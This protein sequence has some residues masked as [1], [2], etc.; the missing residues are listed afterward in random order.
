MVVLVVLG[1]ISV[2]IADVLSLAPT[3]RWFVAGDE[4]TGDQRDAAMKLPGRQSA[5][6]FAAWG[7]IVLDASDPELHRIA[8][9]IY[10][11]AVERF[12]WTAIAD[13]AGESYCALKNAAPT[14]SGSL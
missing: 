9:P 14:C 1:T 11:A 8:A 12:S 4:P 10:R 6:L 2:A 3:L 7:V 13:A 5:I